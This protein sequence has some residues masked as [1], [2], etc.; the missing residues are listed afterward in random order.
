MEGRDRGP[1]HQSRALIMQTVKWTKGKGGTP[2]GPQSHLIEFGD[3]KA[4]KRDSGRD[5]R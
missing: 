4:V 2:H 1:M 5:G 3:R